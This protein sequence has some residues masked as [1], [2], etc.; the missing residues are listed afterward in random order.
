MKRKLEQFFL[1]RYRFQI[2]YVILGLVF[3]ALLVF[4]PNIAPGGLSEAEM[5]SVVRSES[6]TLSSVFDGENLANLPYHLLQK[7]S[8]ILFGP[9]IYAIKLPSILV[10]IATAVFLVLLLNR[11]FKSNVAVIASAIIT[12]SSIFLFLSGS[13]TPAICYLF[14]LALILWLG[15]KIVGAK[16]PHPVLVTAFTVALSVSIYTSYLIYL[17]LVILLAAIMHPHM[18]FVIKKAH[19]AQI[20]TCSVT[21]VAILAPLGIGLLNN[22]GAIAEFTVNVTEYSYL[23]NLTSAFVPFFSFG[24]AY[25]SVFLSPLF[26]LAT[27]ALLLVGVLASMRKMF[28][29]RNTVVSLLVLFAIFGS[30]LNPDVAVIIVVP[31]AVLVAAGLESIVNKW[32]S[33]FPE[34]PYAQVAGMLPMAVFTLIIILSSLSHFVFGYQYTPAV[35]RQFNDDLVLVGSN[36][37]D[38]AV[39]IAEDD[40]DYEFYSAL[41]DRLGIVVMRDWPQDVT[42]TVATLGKW[43]GE[44]DTEKFS[45]SKIVT[46]QKSQD[47]DRL[48]IYN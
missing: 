16:R 14:W 42:T 29:S 47:S 39:L 19:W 23:D 24:S 37:S 2:S 38:G 25:E 31:I 21:T 4:L 10:G 45:L 15:S 34:N 43:D 46:S 9:S 30:G 17:A 28:T 48:Y 6:L 7:V 36:L 27:V 12:L 8:L 1:Y 18:R 11:W 44:L 26:G 20:L 3:V 5:E 35:A 41:A 32:Y 22:P 13:G 40:M 33:L